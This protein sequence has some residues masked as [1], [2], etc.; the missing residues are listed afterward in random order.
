MCCEQCALSGLS[1]G[2]VYGNAQGSGPLPGPAARKT[3]SPAPI[4]T[5]RFFDMG[6]VRFELNLPGLNAV[7]KSDGIQAQ[8]Q[9]AGEAVAGAADGNY[10][11]ATHMLNYFA[12]VNV[13]PAD[14]ESAIKNS[15][16]NELLK[17]LG[18]AGLPMSK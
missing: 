5:R 18:A 3:P 16:N 2:A 1:G 8:L 4:Y 7:M 9:E 15:R 10:N 12:Q 13:Y 6:K 17:A 14:R 11:T